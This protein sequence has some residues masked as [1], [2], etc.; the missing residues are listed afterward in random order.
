MIVPVPYKGQNWYP[1][2]D[3]FMT[4]VYPN[5]YEYYK[6]KP[7][8]PKKLKGLAEQFAPDIPKLPEE[9]ITF[10]QQIGGEGLDLNNRAW[11]YPSDRLY[12]S[13]NEETCL[14]IGSYSQL[15]EGDMLVYCFPTEEPPYLAWSRVWPGELVKVAGSLG[16]LLCNQAFL[17]EG[18]EQFA[19][20]YTMELAFHLR[21]PFHGA[22]PEAQ[23]YCKTHCVEELSEYKLYDMGFQ[24]QVQKLEVPIKELGYERAWFSTE[25]DHIWLKEDTCC[26]LSRDFDPNDMFDTVVVSLLGMSKEPV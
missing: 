12:Q 5:W 8:A 6:C 18:R 26:I 24:I 17:A 4:A 10:F 20:R 9:Y 1:S 11:F 13:G 16:Q 3:G 7:T 22:S 19:F 15:D 25:L 23:E 21:H 2:F 14:T